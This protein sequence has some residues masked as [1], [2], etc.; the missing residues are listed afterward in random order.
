MST[1]PIPFTHEPET[2]PGFPCRA[3]RWTFRVERWFIGFVA[4]HQWADSGGWEDSHTRVVGL[5]FHWR[6]WQLGPEHAY[7]DGP[8]CSFFV[9]P[10]S[11]QWF[12]HNCDRCHP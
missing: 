1:F 6:Y 11:A 4:Q 3:F 10:F 9:G 12:S 2:R 8:H 7:Y 5:H